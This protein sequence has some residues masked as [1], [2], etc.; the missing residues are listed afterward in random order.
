M[1][2]TSS[3]A[4]RQQHGRRR[5]DRFQQEARN[6]RCR[7]LAVLQGKKFAVNVGFANTIESFIYIP[8]GVQIKLSIRPTSEA[9]A[10]GQHLSA[11]LSRQSTARLPA[12]RPLRPAK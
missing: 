8:D 5:D 2:G 11:R 12:S 1:H 7:L 3:R 6:R 10:S 4:A 9:L